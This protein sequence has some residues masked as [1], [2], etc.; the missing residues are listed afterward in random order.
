[1]LRNG[2]SAWRRCLVVAKG[3]LCLIIP[4]TLVLLVNCSQPNPKLKIPALKIV[5]K[6]PEP[7][8]ETAQVVK[9]CTLLGCSSQLAIEIFGQYKGDFIVAVGTTKEPEVVIHCL[10]HEFPLLGG[11][12]SDF[13]LDDLDELAEV[14]MLSP[15]PNYCSSLQSAKARTS[16]D[17]DG[18]PYEVVVFCSEQLATITRLNQTGCTAN[19]ATVAEY[20]PAKVNIAVYWEGQQKAF[21]EQ[22]RYEVN[23]PNGPDCDS[24]CRFST[25]RINIP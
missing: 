9:I 24:G 12:H 23:Y 7:S 10:P 6:V 13:R 16:N 25:V 22:P 5:Q 8:P 11:G 14:L 19:T 3:F 1:M 20:T 4:C 15:A 17:I 2:R 18:N 21:T